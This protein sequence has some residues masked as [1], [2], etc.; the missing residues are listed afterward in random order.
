MPDILVLESSIIIISI[1]YPLFTIRCYVWLQQFK[2]Q[3]YNHLK[4]TEVTG[5]GP[6]LD[7]KLIKEQEAEVRNKQFSTTE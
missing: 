2:T 4:Q 5:L 7:W 3:Y 6:L 1:Y